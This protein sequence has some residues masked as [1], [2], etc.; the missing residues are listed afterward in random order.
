[1]EF[2]PILC[3]PNI[4][5]LCFISQKLYNSLDVFCR[6]M[7]AI[8]A[9]LCQHLELVRGQCLSRSDQLICK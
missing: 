4:H 2:F 3:L 6:H 7:L 1:M 9:Y 5:P 8:L